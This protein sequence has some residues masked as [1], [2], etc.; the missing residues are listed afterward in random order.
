MIHVEHRA[1][2]ERHFGTFT[3]ANA[4]L[5]VTRDDAGREHSHQ[6]AANAL[7]TYRG[8][9]CHLSDLTVGTHLR[10]TLEPVGNMATNIECL[11]IPGTTID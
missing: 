8:S 2:P 9:P 5:L 6:V 3:S 4:G 10:I 11:R 1:E 7:V